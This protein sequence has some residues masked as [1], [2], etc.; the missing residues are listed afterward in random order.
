MYKSKTFGEPPDPMHFSHARRQRVTLVLVSLYVH[1]AAVVDFFTGSKVTANTYHKTRHRAKF[2]ANA[3]LWVWLFQ[4]IEQ[5]GFHIAIYWMS[6]HTDTDPKK[7]KLA[8]SWMQE[9]HV[10]GNNVADKL[11]DQAAAYHGIPNR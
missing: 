1:D 7:K 10:K 9:W 4:L 6:S 5:K 8:P 2:A 11:A 3:D